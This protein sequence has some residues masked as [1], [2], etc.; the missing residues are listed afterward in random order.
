MAVGELADDRDERRVEQR[1]DVDHPDARGI[2]DAKAKL[3]DGAHGGDHADVKAA[4]GQAEKVY[5]EYCAE[6]RAMGLRLGI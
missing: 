1:V 5:G 3:H 6:V 4:D 2:I